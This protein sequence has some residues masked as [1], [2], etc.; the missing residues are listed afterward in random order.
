MY[1]AFN[2][3]DRLKSSLAF[4]AEEIK[5]LLIIILVF[6]F[7]I[8]FDDGRSSFSFVPWLF[9][10]FNVLLV[11]SLSV[12][13]RETAHRMAATYYGLKVELKLSTV[14]LTIAFIIGMLTLG[15][16]TILMYGGFLLSFIPRQ[17]LGYFRFGLSYNN[18]AMVAF[19]GNV[20]N[21][22]LALLFKIFSYLPNPLIQKAMVI[23]IALACVNMIPIPPLPGSS[24]L[25]ASR[26]FYVFS[27]ALI[28]A[29]GLLMLATPLLWTLLGSAVIAIA[30]TIIYFLYFESS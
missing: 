3:W 27:L 28:V 10:F 13:L 15:K 26:T 23:N 24:I 25:F 5:S 6:T 4:S 1:G 20:A 22:M 17:R 29:A 21:L 11:V 16:V 2:F 8:G 9:N 12:L 14:M 7:M 18:M 30:L 19:F